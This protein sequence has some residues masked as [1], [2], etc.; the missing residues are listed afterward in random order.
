MRTNTYI[1]SGRAII[2]LY[3]RLDFNANHEF[4]SAYEPILKSASVTELEIDLNAVQYL[5][6]SALGM[7][8][9]L[10]ERAE[11]SG[12]SVVLSNC[13]GAVKQILEVANFLKLFKVK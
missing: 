12:K 8:L 3:G 10:K 7:L 2:S 4:K 6:S 13:H 9:L 1:V 11:Q 5:D